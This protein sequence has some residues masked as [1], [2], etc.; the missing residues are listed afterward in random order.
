MIRHREYEATSRHV[1]SWGAATILKGSPSDTHV[2]INT[3]TCLSFVL[4][5]PLN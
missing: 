1:A 4:F 3:D 5:V 2:E